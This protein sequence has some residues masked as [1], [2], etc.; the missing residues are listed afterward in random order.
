MFA[1]VKPLTMLNHLQCTSSSVRTQSFQQ[2]RLTYNQKNQL[3][4]FTSY[5]RVGI[6]PKLVFNLPSHPIL[7]FNQ[8]RKCLSTPIV[9]L[10]Y[11][12]G[13][14]KASHLFQFKQW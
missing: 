2:F 6:L 4:L 13:H 11:E 1:Q 10:K 12:I 3:R 8:F 5:N 9:L 14:S 7:C